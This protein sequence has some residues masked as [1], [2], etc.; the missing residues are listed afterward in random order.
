MG[1]LYVEPCRHDNGVSNTDNF[2]NSCAIQYHDNED[3][4]TELYFPVVKDFKLCFK[5][6]KKHKYIVDGG[7][8]MV[9]KTL[10]IIKTEKWC[11]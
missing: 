3:Q 11:G 2:E 7:T 5:L 6:I 10:Y 4:D 8:V 1:A 9:I